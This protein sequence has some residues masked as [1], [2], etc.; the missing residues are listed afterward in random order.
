MQYVKIVHIIAQGQTL[1]RRL[2]E[3]IEVITG[4]PFD[5]ITSMISIIIVLVGISII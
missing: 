5:P 1:K 3:P 2:P 4:D